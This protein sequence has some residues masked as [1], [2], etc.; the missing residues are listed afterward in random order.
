MYLQPAL[1]TVR[2]DTFCENRGTDDNESAE[3]KNKSGDNCFQEEGLCGEI[4]EDGEVEHQ[5]CDEAVDTTECLEVHDYANDQH[6]T[7]T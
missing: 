1:L 2:I 4:D 3:N 5:E 6:D 7:G